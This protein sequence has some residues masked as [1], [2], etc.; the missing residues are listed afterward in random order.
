M[1][2]HDPL[3]TPPEPENKPLHRSLGPAHTLYPSPPGYIA[4]SFLQNIIHRFSLFTI[5]MKI[6]A[7]PFFVLSISLFAT[8]FLHE[9][10]LPLMLLTALPI[11]ACWYLDGFF[12]KMET[13]Y[14]NFYNVRQPQE[15]HTVG[16]FSSQPRG[17]LYDLNPYSQMNLQENHIAKFIF[18]K[19][20]LIYYLTLLFPIFFNTMSYLL[21]H[22]L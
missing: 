4:L 16:F 11:L 6:L 2:F 5:L 14:R 7:A 1:T 9:M 21:L 22:T 20:L 13:I 12:L 19:T 10:P 17:H 18:S 8:S 3:D 15:R